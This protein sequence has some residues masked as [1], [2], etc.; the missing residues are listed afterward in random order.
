MAEDEQR[1]IRISLPQ[2]ERLGQRCNG[3]AACSVGKQRRGNTNRAE[4]VAVC[5]DDRH[6]GDFRANHGANGIH[7]AGKRGEVNL[8]VGVARERC[9]VCINLCAAHLSSSKNASVPKTSSSMPV[10]MQRSSGQKV[11]LCSICG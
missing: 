8:N 10:L 2:F 3:K 5:F 11:S 6:D 9:R 7:V 1:R 4:A